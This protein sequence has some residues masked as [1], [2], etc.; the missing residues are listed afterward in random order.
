M[1]SSGIE[2]STFRLVAQYL[3]QLHHHLTHLFSAN[4]ITTTGNRNICV[5]ECV[6]VRMYS[7]IQCC[8]YI[9]GIWCI[10]DIFYQS[11]CVSSVINNCIPKHGIHTFPVFHTGEEG[12]TNCRVST[13][14]EHMCSSSGGQNCIIQSLVSSHLQVAVPCTD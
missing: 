13:C 3:S 9:F 14:F 1:T 8:L 12:R 4:A 7:L 10:C 6:P 2:P 5:C 11:L